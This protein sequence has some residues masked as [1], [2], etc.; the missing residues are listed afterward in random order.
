MRGRSDAARRIQPIATVAVVRLVA[1]STNDTLDAIA[2]VT[3]AN[4]AAFAIVDPG[5][6]AAASNVAGNLDL[7]QR[8][9]TSMAKVMTPQF[10]IASSR[11]QTDGK[12]DSQ[13]MSSNATPE[14]RA[15]NRRVEFAKRWPA[16]EHDACS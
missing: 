9:A 7:S 4:G 11:F 16:T 14:G 2:L 1:V 12:V 10:G 5:K 13:P 3:L 8:R 15:M 6:R